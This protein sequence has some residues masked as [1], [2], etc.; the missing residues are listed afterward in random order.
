MEGAYIVAVRPDRYLI[1]GAP[2]SLWFDP[3]TGDVQRVEVK[4][5]VRPAIYADRIHLLN[6]DE[7]CIT[8]LEQDTST[9]IPFDK[10]TWI[11]AFAVAANGTL[12]I[13]E[14]VGSDKDRG[15]I[16]G[17]AEGRWAPVAAPFK[18]PVF[19][20][21]RDG[22]KLLAATPQGIFSYDS[23]SDLWAGEEVAGSEWQFSRQSDQLFLLN[24]NSG[25]ILTRLNGRWQAERLVVPLEG[26]AGKQTL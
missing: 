7:F 13:A 8:I 6:G 19:D 16:L 5:T 10:G 22:E 3:A 21:A 12:F 26:E 1:A 4:T 20:L 9:V 25:A 2:F 18:G 15:R 11:D 17:Y 23:R 24:T 14:R